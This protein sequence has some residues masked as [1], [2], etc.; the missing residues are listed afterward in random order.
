LTEEYQGS[1]SLKKGEVKMERKVII[2]M[3]VLLVLGVHTTLAVEEKP[4]LVD[5]NVTSSVQ[6]DWVSS[7]TDG[8]TF[9]VNGT[10]P[11]DNISV[12]RLGV[13]DHLGDGLGNSHPIG[14]WDS[15]GTL[16]VSTSIPSE[17]ASP[18]IGGYRYVDITPVE[19]V[20]G[21]SYTIGV[22]MGLIVP[23]DHVIQSASASVDSAIT[24]EPSHPDP[25]QY[26]HYV[27]RCAKGEQLAQPSAWLNDQQGFNANF[28]FTSSP[29]N[30]S[31]V[32]DAGPDQTI[33]CACQTP[34]GT[35][36]TLDG[37]GSSDS[38]N[39]LLTYTWTGPFVESP[40]SGATPIITLGCIGQYE[41]TL[42][43]ND[44]QEDSAPDTVIITVVDT[45]APVI[46]HPGDITVEAMDPDG[47]PVED[48]EIQTFLAGASA[49]D[50][51]DP[52]PT[53]V[54]NAPAV[55]QPGDT[56][57]TF[58]ATDASGNISTCQSTVTVVEAA[59]AHIR[60]V[61]RI[62][63]R[64][65]RLP[66]IL[67]VIRFPEGITEDDID[68][69]EPLVLFPGD[70]PYGIE[71][72]CQRIVTWRRWGKLHVSIFSFFPKDDI[73]SAIPEDGLVELIVVGRLVNG[74]YF[75][76]IDTVRIISWHWKHW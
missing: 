65:G 20:A 30:Q 5:L 15:G 31:P 60:I 67:A 18:L 4:A 44:G 57:V 11:G 47:V 36:V 10:A 39:N 13:Y 45:T 17:T 22:L 23:N 16:I 61:P 34:E 62:I 69:A 53:I 32:A 64:D 54:N 41:I 43:V 29:S 58:T 55:F 75:Y 33:E 42:V 26:P 74:Q 24:I 9:T 72:T 21:Q 3:V 73:T 68:M 35:Q 40:A 52:S 49:T 66:A 8:W 28:Q 12:T 6:G 46:S 71:A 50:N 37:T 56:I 7:R 1:L 48:D 25:Q 27:S 38:D 51:C 76:G 63:N 14:L 2:S 19:L 70:S 59:E